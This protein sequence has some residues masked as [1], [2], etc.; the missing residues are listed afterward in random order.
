[1]SFGRRLALFFL[2]IV[3]VPTLALVA[4]VL[5]VS[6]ES[7]SG[8]A[9]ARLAAG[10]DTATGLYSNRVEAALPEARALAGD[11]A[12]AEAIV[13]EDRTGIRSFAEEAVLASGL[14]GVEVLGPDGEEL[15]SAGG[16]DAVAF[17]S[18]RLAQ[19]GQQSGTLRVSQ[20]TAPDY[21]GDV[22]RLTRRE[23]VM[24]REGRV[25][26][27]TVEAPVDVLDP[28]ETE[29]IRIDG[30]EFR[31]HRETLDPVDDE[32]LLMLGPTREGGFLP[33]GRRAAL[34]IIGFLLLAGTLGYT[35][36]RALARLHDRVAEQAETDPLTG[37]FN[38]RRFWGQLSR[39]VERALRFR[40]PL[41]L[42]IYDIDDFKRINDAH[43]HLTGDEVIKMMGRIGKEVARSIDFAAR[44]GG[45][46][47][48]VILVETDAEGAATFA[49]RLRSTVRE[50]QIPIRGGGTLTVTVS[51]GA[52]TVPDAATEVEALV[53]AAD[54]ALLEAK[55]LG[56]DQI[57][58]A[59]GG[60]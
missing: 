47:F 6:E 10:L 44:Y 8:K 15:G 37:V 60:G 17:A 59:P 45:D 14:Q 43:G 28:G 25:V 5:F 51:V 46:E 35:L 49:E 57:R 11:P 54:T 52:A 27:A 31:A 26:G 9:D 23:V 38:R 39:E 50:T 16:P 53:H 3:L 24:S 56:K 48:A 58:Q 4:V 33:I 36:T 30:R 7:R 34:V 22:G 21:V 20:T 55:R 2:L 12:L 18:I 41:S 13:G 19:G 32:T 42:L 29:D 1:V 40:H